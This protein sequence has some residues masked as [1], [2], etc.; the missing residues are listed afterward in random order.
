VRIAAPSADLICI[1]SSA[2]D[3]GFLVDARAAIPAGVAAGSVNDVITA[4]NNKYKAN[5]NKPFSLA[6]ID[7]GRSALQSMGDGNIT[8]VGGYIAYNDPP[9]AN[10]L[11]NFL[12]ACTRAVTS[13]TFYGCNV[14]SGADGPAFL[15]ELATGGAMQMTAYTGSVYCNS[16]GKWS[17]SDNGNTVRKT[18]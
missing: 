13:C 3:N 14:A 17:A 5:G 7:H 9:S 2:A 1:S 6:V 18:P 11:K 4:I 16:H 8:V 15:Q 10:D 12:V